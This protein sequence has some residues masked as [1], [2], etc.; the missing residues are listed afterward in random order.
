MSITER[1]RRP[2]AAVMVGIDPNN[3]YS[4]LGVSPLESTETIRRIGNERIRELRRHL[5]SRTTQAFSEVEAEIVRIQAILETIASPRHR[6]CT[7][8]PTRRAYS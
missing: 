8:S 1:D 2:R 4:Q 6:Q 3:P 5:K 7:T